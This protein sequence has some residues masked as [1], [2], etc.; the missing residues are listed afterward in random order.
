MRFWVIDNQ[1]QVYE[2]F[3][4]FYLV[5]GILYISN[6]SSKNYK[7]NITGSLAYQK[8]IQQIHSTSTFHFTDSRLIRFVKASYWQAS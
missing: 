4:A 8:I 7:S 1:F 3:D 2:A 6:K 5:D